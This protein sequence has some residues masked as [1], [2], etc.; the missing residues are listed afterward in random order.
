MQL[1]RTLLLL[2]STVLLVAF[3]A[4]NW[5]TVPLNL[6]PLQDG[7]YVH[8]EWPVGFIVIV[9]MALGFLP[10]WLLHKGARWQLNRRIG[11][12]E[13]AV[14]A[15]SQT[16]PSAIGTTTQLETA[17]TQDPLAPPQ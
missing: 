13:N 5:Q 9:A 4:I 17:T 1:I 14:K 15:N 16:A 2:A 10:M 11:F 7:N 12:L 8:L 6:W 3:I